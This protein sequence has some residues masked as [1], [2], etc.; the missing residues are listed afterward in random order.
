MKYSQGMYKKVAIALEQGL[1]YCDPAI[2]SDF[3]RAS[4]SLLRRLAD[5]MGL[6]KGEYEIS[7]SLAGIAV[8]GEIILHTDYLYIVISEGGFMPVM[9]KTCDGMKDYQGGDNHWAPIEALKDIQVFADYLKLVLGGV[10]T[11]NIW[12]QEQVRS[13]LAHYRAEM[14]DEPAVRQAQEDYEWGRIEIDEYELA[15]RLHDPNMACS[16][17]DLVF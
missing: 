11:G 5:A 10:A 15:I 16:Q 12:N 1:S 9:Y 4:K 3:H 7:S 13:D 17:M 2:K 8:S 6:E 14:M